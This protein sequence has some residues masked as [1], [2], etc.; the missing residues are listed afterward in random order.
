M[1]ASDMNDARLIRPYTGNPTRAGHLS[2]TETRGRSLRATR[3]WMLATIGL[4]AEESKK[5]NC[6]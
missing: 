4:T 3:R 6:Q 1:Q 2:N 5:C